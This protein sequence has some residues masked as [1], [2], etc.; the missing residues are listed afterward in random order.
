MTPL[1]RELQHLINLMA[2]PFRNGWA[3][4]CWA[5]ALG[6]AKSDPENYAEL[7]ERLKA[8]MRKSSAS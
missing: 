8:S 2:P 4:Y 5:K 6:L 7:P 3:Q 1:E